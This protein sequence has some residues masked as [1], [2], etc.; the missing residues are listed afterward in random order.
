MLLRWLL[1]VGVSGA[2]PQVAFPVNAQVPPVA[3]P[4]EPYSFQ[5]SESTFASAGRGTL[6]Y[7]IAR[8]PAW[9]ALDSDTRTFSGIPQATDVGSPTFELSAADNDGS[10]PLQV[11]F[12]VSSATGPQITANVSEVLAKAGPLPDVQSVALHPS[13]P[14]SIAFGEESFEASE[15]IYYYATMLDRSPLPSWIRFDPQM[16]AFSGA[17][18]AV[19]ANPQSFAI[20]LIAS[21][22]AGFAGL[23]MTLQL[24]VSEHHLAFTILRQDVEISDGQP[25]LIGNLRSQ[26][27]LD[28]RQIGA[29][30][31]ADAQAQLP[32]WLSFDATTLSISGTAPAGVAFQVVQISVN[33]TYGDS[34]RAYLRLFPQSD[35]SRTTQTSSAPSPAKVVGSQSPTCS[36]ASSVNSDM[37]RPGKTGHI[38]KQTQTKI[39]VSVAL[40]MA[41]LCCLALV[42]CCIWKNKRRRTSPTRHALS[43]KGTAGPLCGISFLR[44]MRSKYRRDENNDP[45]DVEERQAEAERTIS[46]A[47]KLDIRLASSPIQR[48]S[49]ESELQPHEEAILQSQNRSSTGLGCSSL[50]FANGLPERPRPLVIRPRRRSAPHISCRSLQNARIYCGFRPVRRSTG[51]GHGRASYGSPAQSVLL[52]WPGSASA[53]SSSGWRTTALG[54]SDQSSLGYSQFRMISEDARMN[55]VRIVPPE[56]SQDSA[57]ALN[58]DA[59]FR[60]KRQN[61]IRERQ[62]SPS[63]GWT[64]FPETDQRVSSRGC[65]ENSDASPKPER[66]QQDGGAAT[67]AEY[68]PVEGFPRVVERPKTRSKKSRGQADDLVDPFEDVEAELGRLEALHPQARAGLSE[69]GASVPREKE[70]DLKSP[71]HNSFPENRRDSKLKRSYRS[72]MLEVRRQMRQSAYYREATAGGQEADDED[73]DELEKVRG[74]EA[75]P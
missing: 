25:V 33:D 2:V 75:F 16:V 71:A 63:F 10:V 61:F 49:N 17:A 55:S 62:K 3:V 24:L 66:N 52:S 57:S 6:S 1:L 60:A 42:G 73:E 68:N 48:F 19:G 14:F 64:L 12:V 31:V 47:P 54:S 28:G 20:C 34:A 22:I 58:H 18:P 44:R 38:S 51:L 27:A 5:F 11:T 39:A 29:Q 46:P 67:V 70:M 13:S 40:G 50:N 4:N 56:D 37:N 32:D 59:S 8:A 53:D 9:L 21:S 26:L 41:V 36:G 69:G 72:T 74:N 23:L 65:R 35:R 45:R 7:S 43:E 30:E 15:N